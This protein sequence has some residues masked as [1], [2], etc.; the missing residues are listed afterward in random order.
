MK[1]IFAIIITLIAS[2]S[3]SQTYQSNEMH[4]VSE[5][6][7]IDSIIPIK[8]I[9]KIDESKNIIVVTYI[10]NEETNTYYEIIHSSDK[11]QEYLTKSLLDESKILV[12]VYKNQIKFC[13][14]G[15]SPEN[16]WCALYI[17]LE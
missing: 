17:R 15:V 16:K 13:S 2:Y 6:Y 8:S 10:G 14:I 12:T 11:Y 1:F 7:I 3:Y 9:I 4:I 5:H